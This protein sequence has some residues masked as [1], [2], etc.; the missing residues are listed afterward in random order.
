MEKHIVIYQGDGYYNF[1]KI[2][3][4]KAYIKIRNL[5]CGSD[6][7]AINQARRILKDKDAEIEIQGGKNNGKNI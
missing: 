1:D 7:A 6:T 2:D 4:S 3:Q 5:R